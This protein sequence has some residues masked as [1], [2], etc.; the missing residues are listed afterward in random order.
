MAVPFQA[1]DIAAERTE[2]GHPDVA[3]ILT[4][5]HYYHKG[6]SKTQLFDSFLFM[7][8]MDQ[9][10]AKAINSQWI[11]IVLTDA[12]KP[13]EIQSYDCVNLKDT[14]LFDDKLYQAFYKNMHVIYFWLTKLI[15]PNQAKQFPKKVTSTSWDLCKAGSVVTTGFSGTNDHDNVL[16]LTVKSINLDS[17]KETNGIQ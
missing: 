8:H 13:V 3:L 5:S 4:F 9:S 2:Y 12:L 17:L 1:K 15:Y 6:L 10:E 11:N 16:P 7:H 14:R